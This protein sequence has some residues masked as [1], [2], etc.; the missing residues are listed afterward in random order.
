MAVGH[1]VVA[2]INRV[3]DIAAE[4]AAFNHKLS[5]KSERML[6]F[7]AS[8]ASTPENP[9]LQAQG[10]PDS[11]FLRRLRRICRQSPETQAWR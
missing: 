4:T 8:Y 5:L 1:Q 9:K 7:N 3:A 2:G 11:E 6:S 10:V